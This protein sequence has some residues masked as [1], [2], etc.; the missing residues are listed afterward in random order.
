MLLV[1]HLAR[2]H[3]AEDHR[4]LLLPLHEVSEQGL[5]VAITPLQRQAMLLEIA[6]AVFTILAV[7]VMLVSAN[8]A[9]RPQWREM[10]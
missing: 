9:L 5:A 7:L 4:L 1:L 6:V 8:K 3:H 2:H 10:P